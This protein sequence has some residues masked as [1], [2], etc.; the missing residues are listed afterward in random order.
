MRPFAASLIALA[1]VFGGALLGMFC[2]RWVPDRHKGPD[3]KEVVRLAM[4]LV[5]TTSAMAL[6]S[7]GRFGQELLRYAKCRNGSDRRKLRHAGPNPQLLRV[8]NERRTCCAAR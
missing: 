7:T 3:S 4:G 8:G 1:C 2:R 5:V 6:G